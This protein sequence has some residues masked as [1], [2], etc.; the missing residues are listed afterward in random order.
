MSEHITDLLI[1]WNNGSGEALDRL[2]P[3]VERELRRMAANYMRRESPGHTLQTTALVNE[4]YLKLVDQKSVRW[5]N[6]AHFFAIASQIMRRIL[7]DHARSRGRTKRG[8]EVIHLNLE[9]VAVLSPQKTDE[10]LALDEALSRLASFDAKKSRIVEM[11][12]FGGLT[13][14]E[15]ADVLGIAPVTV[16][17]HWRL[18]KAWLQ[19]EV[20]QN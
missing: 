17:L 10:L 3:L 19:R 11:R 9:D 12:F 6:R 2:I 1:D 14:D 18:A 5:Q 7:V 16:M 8:G 13:V 4:A 20:R 15:V